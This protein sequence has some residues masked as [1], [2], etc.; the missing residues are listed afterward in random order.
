MLETEYKFFRELVTKGME[1]C[2]GPFLFCILV[3][4]S[5]GIEY[6]L[7]GATFNVSWTTIEF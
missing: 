3:F 4:T 1:V 5:Y 6:W 7:Q 2:K